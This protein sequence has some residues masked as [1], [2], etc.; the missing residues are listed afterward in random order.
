MA[1]FP[2][3]K[4]LFRS[5]DYRYYLKA[6]V[7]ELGQKRGYKKDLAA[8][9][10]CQP[11]YLSQVLAGKAELTP[12]QAEKLCRFWNLNEIESEYFFTMVLLGRAGTPTLQERLRTTLGR[13]RVKWEKK[14]GS[15]ETE[16]L[17]ATDRAFVYYSNWL[18]SAIHVLL[19]VPKL[20]NA[21][22]LA[23]HLR[24]KQ[25]EVEKALRQLESTGL[26]LRTEKGWTVT[27]AQIHSPEADLS[28]ALHHR[29][30]RLKGLDAASAVRYTSVHTLSKADFLKVRDLLDEAIRRTRSVIDPSPE[31]MGACLLVD[32]FTL[33]GKPS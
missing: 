12:E 6:V 32:Y 9:A 15:Y 19:T 13:L 25:S 1:T 11:A 2:L 5:N 27:R 8:S 18:H 4:Q 31:E 33:S 26:V 22:A 29:N 16:A 23:D 3:K 28:A 14:Q 20:R 21:R 17:P 24:V 30:W 7:A 10:G